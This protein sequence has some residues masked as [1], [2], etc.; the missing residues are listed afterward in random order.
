MKKINNSIVEKEWVTKEGHNAKVLFLEQGH[1]CGY[2]E[3]KKDSFLFGKTYSYYSF[4]LDEITQDL[5]DNKNK[6]EALNEICIHGGLTYSDDLLKDNSHWFGFDCAHHLD[7]P[8]EESQ[9][10]YYPN[11]QNKY[12]GY[13]S[14]N[15][16]IRTLEFCINECESLSEQIKQIE[17]LK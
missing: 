6:Y 10:K 7:K 12:H 16:V 11:T 13:N 2:V 3:V 9:E 15:S 4:T 14:S 17:D 1:R 5:I 8:D